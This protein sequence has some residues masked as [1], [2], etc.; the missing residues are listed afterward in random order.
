MGTPSRS[1]AMQSADAPEIEV[2]VLREDQ[3]RINLFGRL[4]NKRHAIEDRIKEI[5]EKLT[6]YED[7][8]TEMM[9][10]DDEDIKYA[11]G[12]TFSCFD[13]DSAGEMLEEEMAKMQKELEAQEAAMGGIEEEMK[14][15]KVTLYA[16]FGK[17]INLEE[18][19]Q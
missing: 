9:L 6:N 18:N 2:E 16:K 10:L 19:P 8:Q 5:K 15:L 1:F 3:K 11:V 17:S 4:N 7:A 13:T 12:D 14:E